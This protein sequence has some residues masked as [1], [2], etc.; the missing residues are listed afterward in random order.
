MKTYLESNFSNLK[1]FYSNIH[2][3]DDLV[4]CMTASLYAE[5]DDVIE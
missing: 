1:E 4:V 3:T 2:N 5:K